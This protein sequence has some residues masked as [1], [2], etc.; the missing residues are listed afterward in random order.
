M[1]MH[2]IAVEQLELTVLMPCLDEA[3]T[4]GG[5][6]RAARDFIERE[7]IRA[8]ILV[9]D[10][11]SK[12]DSREV[13]RSLGARVIQVQQRGYGAA[14]FA[15]SHAARG[16]YIVM[17]DADGSYDFSEIDSI[18]KKLRGGAEL[19]MG[20]RFAGGIKDR[21]M[22]WKN[23][24]IGNPA[25]TAIGQVLFGCPVRDFHCGLRG[26]SRSAF[27]RMDLRTTGMEFASEMV[28]KSTLLKM[29]IEEVPVTLS[30]DGRG[31]PSHLR[32]WRDGWRHLRFM[33]LFSPRWILLYPALLM[34]ALGLLGAFAL[35]AGPI[36]IGPVGLGVHTMIY[37]TALAIIGFQVTLF[38]M[39]S[40]VFACEHGLVPRD[41]ALRRLHSVIKL[42][43]G[44]IV[45]GLV[46]LAGFGLAAISLADWAQ[47]GFG[48]LDPERVMRVVAPSALL[49]T[50]GVQAI[51]SSFFFSMLGLHLRFRSGESER[52]ALRLPGSP[53]HHS[54][55]AWHE[56]E[57]TDA[58]PEKEKIAV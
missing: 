57:D 7:G 14:L 48:K 24:Y 1:L 34:T 11:G 52:A 58:E 26:F 44:L 4:L 20:N 23:R 49:M 28:I 55:G 32:P 16:K 53:I 39:F 15:G 25:L 2:R 41:E 51:F 6:I 42:E 5:C 19:V 10:N 33:L 36:K 27:D 8:E 30:P 31:R 46:L 40:R 3:G 29:K 50:F 18:L 43:T 21:A 37:C 12:D 38:A 56:Q 54:A 13:A 22:P 17:G 47:E 45:G 9:A 35:M